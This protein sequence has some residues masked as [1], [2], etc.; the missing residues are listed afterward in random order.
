MQE[1]IAPRFLKEGDT[2]GIFTPSS[3]SYTVNP[4]LFEN[5][6]KNLRE[7]GF[8]I[9]L[10]DL[11]KNMASE[12]YRSA[13]GKERAQEFMNL[14]NDPSVNGL[15]S[16]IGGYNSNSMIEFLDFKKISNARKVICGYSDVTSLHLAI[17]KYS[18]LRTFYGP[19]VMCWFG[20]W[21]NG[22]SESTNWFLDSVMNHKAGTREVIAPKRWSNHMRDWR[23][24]DWKNIEREWHKNDGW[25]SLSP[26]KVRAE[27]IAANLNTLLSAAGTPYWP[28]LKGKVLL[29]EEMDAPLSKEERHLTQLKLMGVF[30]EISGLIIS[31]P[32]IYNNEGAP[33]SYDDLIREIIGKRDYPIISNFDCGHIVPMITIAQEVLVEIEAVTDKVTFKFLEAA[34]RE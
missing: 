10:G 15:I 8:K 9:K 22:V 7:M 31:K 20:E 1:I 16:T 21:P 2:I 27:I 28:N 24:G 34:C 3:P 23:N 6:L 30:D 26:G 13:S 14:I 29:I 17:L 5:G 11:T 4:E 33:F 19:A 12:G 18:R 32:E 25:R